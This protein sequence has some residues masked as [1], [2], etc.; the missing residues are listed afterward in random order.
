MARRKLQK[1]SNASSMTGSSVEIIKKSMNI[2]EEIIDFKE[3]ELECSDIF[4]TNQWDMVTREVQHISEQVE[5]IT[6]HANLQYKNG[7]KASRSEDK[8]LKE[9]H[10][11]RV[12][13]NMVSLN[14]SRERK[15]K[16]YTKTEEDEKRNKSKANYKTEST[17][18]VSKVNKA[19]PAYLL[20]HL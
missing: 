17:T 18:K 19:Y 20:Q 8:L 7:I 12:R 9:N 3:P 4:L 2:V 11:K 10:G 15:E 16:K 13:T 5:Q 6:P 1:L 14:S